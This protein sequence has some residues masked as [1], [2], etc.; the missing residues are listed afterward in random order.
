VALRQYPGIP[1][2]PG[3][4]GGFEQTDEVVRQ[5]VTQARQDSAAAAATTAAAGGGD[6]TMRIQLETTRINSVDYITAEQ[7][8]ALA[9]A[10][11][12]RSTAKQQRALQ[13]SPGARRGI[14]I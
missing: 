12:A 3:T 13:A 9:N 14:G 5:L 6:G 10:A 11:A 4:P 8:A 7:A 2:A 1:G